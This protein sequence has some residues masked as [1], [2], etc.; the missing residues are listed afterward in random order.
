MPQDLAETFDIDTI[1]D[2]V[3]GKRVAEHMEIFTG[4]AGLIL[5]FFK[6]ILVGSGF[7]RGRIIQ[8]IFVGMA[9]SG[10]EKYHFVG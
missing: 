3:C 7:Q 9:E 4:D 1:S 10:Q 2:A 8:H 6:L 5:V